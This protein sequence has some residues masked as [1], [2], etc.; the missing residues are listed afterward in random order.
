[1]RSITA[2][3]K[4]ELLLLV[5]DKTGLLLLF[6]MPAVLVLVITLIQ[7]NVL[8]THVDILFMDQDQGR[9]AREVDRLLSTA[10]DLTLVK[11][12]TPLSQDQAQAAVARGDYQFCIIIPKGA[13]R[14]VE[15]QAVTTQ[16]IAA[17]VTQVSQGLNQISDNI[18]HS[19]TASAEISSDISRVSLQAG[20]IQS[21]STLVKAK[22][23]DLLGLSEKLGEIIR[24]FTV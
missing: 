6:L 24:K 8:K 17:N 9:V 7:E 11:P 22:S 15:E 4:K 2:S 20:E 19:S 16:E 3:I 21:G 1:M 12:E 5:R 13:G 10:P 18:A 23:G 14:A